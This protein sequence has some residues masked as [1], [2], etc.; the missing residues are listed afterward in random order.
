MNLRQTD[1]HI[2]VLDRQTNKQRFVSPSYWDQSKKDGWTLFTPHVG[3]HVRKSNHVSVHFSFW[4]PIKTDR[5]TNY[6]L[7]HPLSSGFKADRHTN[8]NFIRHNRIKVRQT[9][10]LRFILPLNLDPSKTNGQLFHPSYGDQTKTD[11]QISFHPSYWNPRKT[12][13]QTVSF[14]AS[15][16]RF[17]QTDGQTTFNFI[18]HIG[19]HVWQTDGHFISRSTSDYVLFHSHVVVLDRQTD[20]LRFISLYL[21]SKWDRQTDKPFYFTPDIENPARQ[22]KQHFIL[23]IGIFVRQ[24]DRLH[25]I[26]SFILESKHDRRTNYVSFY[27]L[28][29]DQ[30]KTD[31]RTGFVW[32]HPSFWRFRKTDGQITFHFTLV[33]IQVKQTHKLHFCLPLIFG[34]K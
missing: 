4:D 27:P 25:F 9:D 8:V 14:Y 21:S 26:S 1:G 16:W 12:D 18:P 20:Q 29:W 23:H 2:V 5:R 30:S 33:G 15:L 10:R 34:F 13:G 11:R 3:I 7:F 31:T 24:T 17:R 28:F 19:I 6:V 22:T 32:F